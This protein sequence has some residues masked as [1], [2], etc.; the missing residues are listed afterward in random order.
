VD[1]EGVTVLGLRTNLWFDGCAEEAA[2]FY[3]SVFPDSETIS[4]RRPDID[5]P[6]TSAGDV[7]LVEFRLGDSHFVALNGG[8][9]FTLS[10]ATSVEIRCES[11][12]EVDYYWDA[13]LAGGGEPSQCGWLKD[14]FGMSWQVIPEQLGDLIFGP[15]P[16]GAARAMDCMLSM[17]K[18]DL[19]ELKAAYQG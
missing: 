5:T 17:I 11:Q 2:S 8:S 14:R 1:D 7:L 9:Q 3:C 13:L 6:G 10:E 18:L 15:D 4:I 16:Q 19:R 12:A